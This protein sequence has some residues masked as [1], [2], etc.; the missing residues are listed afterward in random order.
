MSKANIGVAVLVAG[1]A[2]SVALGGVALAWVGNAG[3]AGTG[4]TST[5]NC[6]PI[7]VNVL[8]GIGVAGTGAARAGSCDATANGT[9]GNAY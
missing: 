4:G 8:S 7:G 6:V 2:G 1:A 5:N 3:G 9:G